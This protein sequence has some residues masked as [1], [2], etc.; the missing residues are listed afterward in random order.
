[1]PKKPNQKA[2]T[3]SASSKTGSTVEHTDIGRE[4]RRLRGDTPATEFATQSSVKHLSVLRRL[5]TLDNTSGV[6][7]KTLRNLADSVGHKL[8]VRFVPET[9]EH[10]FPQD[11]DPVIEPI[12]H[13]N[14]KKTSLSRAKPEKPRKT[15][16]G[17]L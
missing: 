8:V 14:A 7:V 11:E 4:I 17:K 9:Q 2:D 12:K 1:M 3:K 16:K 5:E 6:S 10:P 13:Q 15:H